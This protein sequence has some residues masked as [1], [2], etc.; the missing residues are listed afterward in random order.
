MLMSQAAIC[1]SMH[2]G[3]HGELQAV[4]DRVLAP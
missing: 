1:S 2:V 4:H 3:G